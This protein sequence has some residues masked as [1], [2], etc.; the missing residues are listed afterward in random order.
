MFEPQF[1]LRL[2]FHRKQRSL[3]QKEAAELCGLCRWRWSDLECGRRMPSNRELALLRRRFDLGRVF[4]SPPKATR[5]LLD[6]GAR[7][8]KTLEPFIAQRD[9][10]THIRYRTCLKR[11][12]ELTLALTARLRRQRGDEFE[13]CQQFCHQASCDSYLESLYILCQLVDGATPALVAP[14]QFDPTPLPIVDPEMRRYAG[15]RPHFCLVTERGHQFYQ[16]SFG[17]SQF[18]VDVLVW[19]GDWKVI[20][21]D[22]DGH[23]SAQDAEREAEI[24]LPTRRL[25]ESEVIAMGWEILKTAA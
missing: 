25:V 11:Q 22:G 23:Y 17:P 24:G 20:E 10:P 3:S 21:L 12:K 16:V 9:R 6:N 1:H 2:K 19:D 14:A 13:L 15:N 18:R 8:T 4:V 5:R 7:L